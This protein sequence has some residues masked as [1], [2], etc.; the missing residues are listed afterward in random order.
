M[1]VPTATEEMLVR[2]FDVPQGGGADEA[3]R[4]GYSNIATMCIYDIGKARPG[5]SPT[6]RNYLPD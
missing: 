1:V 5:D 6:F 3:E 2:V 4:L